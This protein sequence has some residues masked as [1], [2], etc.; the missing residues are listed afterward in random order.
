MTKK[1]IAVCAAVLAAVLVFLGV[2]FLP[3][4]S[5]PYSPETEESSTKYEYTTLVPFA[6]AQTEILT[7]TTVKLQYEHTTR[8]EENASRLSQKKGWQ[9]NDLT[10]GLPKIRTGDVS[11]VEYITDKGRRTVI[12]IDVFGYGSYLNYIDQLEAAG[13]ADNNGRA[14][15]PSSAPSTVAMFYSRFD[16]SRSFGVYWYGA[17][18]DAG[19]NC[20]IVICDYDQAL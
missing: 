2:K 18:S 16:G 20:E 12:R 4:R 19:F 13:F 1:I 3:G 7:P 14:H 15:I 11:T 17:E 9:D 6:P 5:E 8:Y 10:M